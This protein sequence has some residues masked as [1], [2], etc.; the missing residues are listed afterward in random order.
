MKMLCFIILFWYTNLCDA[1]KYNQHVKMAQKQ[2]NIGDKIQVKDD[3]IFFPSINIETFFN[4][5]LNSDYLIITSDQRFRII[6]LDTEDDTQ[7]FL[8]HGPVFL[9]QADSH[10][11]SNVYIFIFPKEMENFKKI[12]AEDE[13]HFKITQSDS[14]NNKLSYEVEEFVPQNGY[15][16][17][18]YDTWNK[19]DMNDI[20]PSGTW[21]EN[22]LSHEVEEF[23][24]RIKPSGTWNENQLSHKVEEFIPQNIYNMKQYDT[25]NKKD[26]NIINE[27]VPKFYGKVGDTIITL[28]SFETKTRKNLNNAKKKYYSILYLNKGKKFI[29]QDVK[30]DGC[31]Y[32]NSINTDKTQTAMVYPHDF[33]KI[34][35]IEDLEFDKVHNNLLNDKEMNLVGA[36]FVSKFDVEHLK[37][38]YNS[39]DEDFKVSILLGNGSI[40]PWGITI[41]LSDPCSEWRVTEVL[42]DLQAHSRGIQK[43]WKLSEW[44]NALISNDNREEVR[45]HLVK[46]LEGSITFMVSKDKLIGQYSEGEIIEHITKKKKWRKATVITLDPLIIDN[47]DSRFSTVWGKIRKVYIKK[48]NLTAKEF[49]DPINSFDLFKEANDIILMVFPSD[50]DVQKSCF[51]YHNLLRHFCTHAHV[52]EVTGARSD[53]ENILK[54]LG[55]DAS[56]AKKLA[57]AYQYAM[58]CH[59]KSAAII[60]Q[61]LKLLDSTNLNTSSEKK[62][63]VIELE[64]RPG[65]RLS[66]I[67]SFE[68]IAY[69]RE[70]IVQ[71]EDI[72]KV[73]Y[74]GGEFIVT[75]RLT[76]DKLIAFEKQHFHKVQF[77][78]NDKRL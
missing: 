23:I 40:N 67:E 57:S 38:T 62:K 15:K 70:F 60:N 29:V 68:I 45:K 74:N 56:S 65:D 13:N 61:I 71:V 5:K 51:Q 41:N 58:L 20:K 4:D 9:I 78:K 37:M 22:N 77:V 50:A 27:F 48:E 36:D 63:K 19:K 18:K 42:P 52:N 10:K 12:D 16:M 30:P 6:G 39:S 3:C 28:R 14:W 75:K 64:S 7:Y 44:R 69:G 43:G 26:T 33:D 72:L 31:I 55:L 17:K 59:G 73:K 76:D 35:V 1:T 2:W 46:E 24:P 53:I 34:K 25:W 49:V 66:V 11:D 54:K 32:I 21:N 8:E 47:L